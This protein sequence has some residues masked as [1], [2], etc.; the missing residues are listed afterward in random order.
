MRTRTRT[1]RAFGLLASSLLLTSALASIA[2]ADSVG[3]FNYQLPEGW[4]TCANVA[5][6][7]GTR[8]L[9]PPKGAAIITIQTGTGGTDP[10]AMARAVATGEVL[11][12]LDGN[13]SGQPG[14]VT[15]A[16]SN[17]AIRV[18]AAT[19]AGG[20]VVVSM[21]SPRAEADGPART[22]GVLVDGASIGAAPAS[23]APAPS[24]S[25]APEPEVPLSVENAS[26]ECTAVMFI[27]GRRVEVPPSG[28]V[29]IQV[30]P[31]KHVFEWQNPDG[32]FG[33]A[34]GEVPPLTRLTGTCI[35]GV[36]PAPAPQAT[37]SEPT[38]PTLKPRD[39]FDGARAAVL[40]Y[41]TCWNLALGGDTWPAPV[42]LDR[43]MLRVMA[44]RPVAKR[45]DFA[46]YNA[47]QKALNDAI[48]RAGADPEARLRL[49][50]YAVFALIRAGMQ[51][52]PRT[53]E[54]PASSTPDQQ[55]SALDCV[56]SKLESAK[57][58]DVL[59]AMNHAMVKVVAA[60]EP[61]PA[62]DLA[63]LAEIGKV[64]P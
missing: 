1:P 62:D 31:G 29:A 44:R 48:A 20:G 9:C 11:K 23:P 36:A 30:R 35:K 3:P 55:R 17:G 43:M 33:S 56:S 47:H 54:P 51:E 41:R 45:R 10:V 61:P 13:V 59:D 14:H 28:K 19:A 15:V 4:T 57:P 49:R 32:S 46:S 38:G 6:P 39:I 26:S 21:I 42:S 24:S 64:T 37:P 16:T 50:R 52:L 18:A 40:F 12:E 8:A 7:A 60:T 2:H 5:S 63:K 34:P 53:C 27:D 22:W 25:P 58:G